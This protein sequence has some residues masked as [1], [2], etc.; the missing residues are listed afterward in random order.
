MKW[1]QTNIVMDIFYIKYV[2][3]KN[4]GGLT[5]L[6]MAAINI[7]SLEYV[8]IVLQKKL[9]KKM[10]VVYDHF[11]NFQSCTSICTKMTND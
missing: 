8:N 3:L 5:P 10:A 11:S 9:K 2:N 7:Q 6:H 1:C 4:K